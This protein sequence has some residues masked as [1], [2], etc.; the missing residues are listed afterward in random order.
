[1]VKI[2]VLYGAPDDP[3]AFEAYFADHHVPLVHKMPSLRRFESALVVAT[4]D[5]SAPPYYRV[6]ELWFDSAEEMQASLATPEGQAPG[7]D[8]PNYATGGATVLIAAID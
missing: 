3:E 2:T 6:A 5:G 1:M 4:P 8:V 7:A